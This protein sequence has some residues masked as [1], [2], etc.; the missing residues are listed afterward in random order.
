MLPPTLPTVRSRTL[1]HGRRI[2]ALDGRNVWAYTVIVLGHSRNFFAIA[3]RL[4]SNHGWTLSRSLLQR[5]EWTS[6]TCGVLASPPVATSIWRDHFVANCKR[7]TRAI[8]WSGADR[9][10]ISDQGIL[11]YRHTPATLFELASYNDYSGWPSCGS[12]EQMSVEYPS[13]SW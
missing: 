7:L 10:A 3:E 13:R 2:T 5:S 8:P 9:E 6:Q 4:L 12:N 11:D 1:S